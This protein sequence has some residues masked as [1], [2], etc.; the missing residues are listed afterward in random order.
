[1]NAHAVATRQGVPVEAARRVFA[2]MEGD[3]AQILLHSVEIPLKTSP[4]TSTS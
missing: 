3:A 4:E 1:V 2:L